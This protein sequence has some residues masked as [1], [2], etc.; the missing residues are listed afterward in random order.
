M[1]NSTFHF[2]L[3]HGPIREAKFGYDILFSPW[4]Q[5]DCDLEAIILVATERIASQ[6]Y[7]SSEAEDVAVG[8]VE[9]ERNTQLSW[10][11]DGCLRG[12][13]VDEVRLISM[14]KLLNDSHNVVCQQ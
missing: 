9:T 8:S 12:D 5:I 6:L 3:M 11:H 7:V 13:S 1:Q 2:N 14:L 10:E 4:F